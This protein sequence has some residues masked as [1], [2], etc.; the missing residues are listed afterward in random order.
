LRPV[1]VFMLRQSTLAT[2]Q[3]VQ[4]LQ[5]GCGSTSGIGRFVVVLLF[6]TKFFV[7]GMIIENSKSS[8]RSS[9]SWGFGIFG[10]KRS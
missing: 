5:C 1:R 7:Q 3:N 2:H 8:R 10:V 9:V 4:P 6:F